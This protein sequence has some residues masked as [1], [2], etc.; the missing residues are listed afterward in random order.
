MRKE[1][2][3]SER[4]PGAALDALRKPARSVRGAIWAGVGIACALAF[5]ALIVA[6]PYTD[7]FRY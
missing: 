6:L 2:H 7:L 1:E 4:V 3:L 5:A